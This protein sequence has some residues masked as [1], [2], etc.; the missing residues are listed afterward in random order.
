MWKEKADHKKAKSRKLTIVMHIHRVGQN[1]I[2][3]R[4]YGV[5]TVF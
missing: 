1:H 4:T 3:I 2:F 5:H